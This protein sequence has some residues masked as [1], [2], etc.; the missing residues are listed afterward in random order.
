M[1]TSEVATQAQVNTQTL[2]YYE[3]RGLLP[4]PERTRSGYRAYTADAV[5][6]VRFIKR[7]QQLGFTL[8]DI[9]DLLHLAHG[10]SASCEETRAMARTRITDLQRR[11]DELVGM[12]DALARLIDTCGQPR[13]ERN[14]PILLDIETAAAQR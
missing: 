8:D 5:R 2:R 3:R 9:E 6:V 1:R 12:R 10:G 13:A 11:I 4:E 14:C 7:A